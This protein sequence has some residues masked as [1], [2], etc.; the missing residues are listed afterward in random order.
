[1]LVLYTAETHRLLK[2][3]ARPIPARLGGGSTADLTRA[4]RWQAGGLQWAPELRF[5]WVIQCR[6]ADAAERILGRLEENGLKR[7]KEG[8]QVHL[9]CDFPSNVTDA[10][11]HAR[12]F[13]GFSVSARKLYPLASGVGLSVEE[14]MS[15]KR[16][17]D[18][19]VADVLDRLT[20]AA[21]ASACAVTVRGETLRRH[22]SLI[23]L[24]VE[25]GVDGI[26]LAPHGIPSVKR[27]V[28][29]FERKHGL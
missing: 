6:D 13:D 16:R 21:H 14:S 27:A 12:L 7:G 22:Q 17:G 29:E 1:M 18:A 28:A 19:M 25:A 15:E 8:L 4:Q 26:S 3:A 10:T 24:F 23:H 5:M 2:G 11:V 20:Q 9:S